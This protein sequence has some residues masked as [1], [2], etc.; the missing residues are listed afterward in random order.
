M[1]RIHA[2]PDDYLDES[3]TAAERVFARAAR[4]SFD[5]ATARI[6]QSVTAAAGAE[7]FISP[8]D[9]QVAATVWSDE[10][11]NL[12]PLVDDAFKAASYGVVGSVGDAILPAEANAFFGI[13]PILDEAAVTHLGQARNRLRR[14]GDQAWNQVRGELLT[15][16]QAGEGIDELAARVRQAGIATEARARTVART[17]VISASNAGSYSASQSLPPVLRPKTK[18]W[19]ATTD[20]RTRPSH[21]AADG[22]VVAMDAEFSVG[23]SSLRFPGDPFGPPGEIINCRCTPLY[24]VDEVNAKC[25][26]SLTA[27][28]QAPVSAYRQARLALGLNRKQVADQ[29]GWSQF[30]L[31]KI[32]LGKEVPTGAELDALFTKVPGYRDKFV[33]LNTATVT[34]SPPSTPVT[35]PGATIIGSCTITPKDTS[36]PKTEPMSAQAPTPTTAPNTVHTFADRHELRDR[37]DE[38][39][40][41]ASRPGSAQADR[42]EAQWSGSGEGGTDWF[43]NDEA[44]EAW[45]RYTRGDYSEMNDYMRHGTQWR[46]DIT[47]NANLFRTAFN[48]GPSLPTSTVYRGIDDD[49]VG[50]SLRIGDTFRDNGFVSTTDDFTVGRDFAGR[51]GSPTTTQNKTFYTIRTT[52]STAQRTVVAGNKSESEWILPPGSEFTVRGISEWVTDGGGR[53]RII[54]I[55]WVS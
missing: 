46:E 51:L 36:P 55:D 52:P 39:S 20:S 13:P 53:H 41:A 49:A 50:S 3:I 14:F 7:Q 44:H 9:A 42:F 33:P 43:A 34:S 15:G 26:E 28:A 38:M 45:L 4:H 2:V 31:D 40:E 30:K 54:E 19:L 17:E 23:G 16:F 37:L 27:A 8:D 18:E 32:E 22:Q 48:D 1:V 6:R 12:L 10:L 25:G 35:L 24:D 47:R 29:L 21:S 11:V 5:A